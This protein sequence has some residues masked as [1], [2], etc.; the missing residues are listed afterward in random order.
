M[1]DDLEP[2]KQTIDSITFGAD[3]STMSVEELDDLVKRLE[4][5]IVRLKDERSHKSKSLD[6]AQAFFKS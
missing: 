4:A 2:K 1:F 5:E 6:A 3:L